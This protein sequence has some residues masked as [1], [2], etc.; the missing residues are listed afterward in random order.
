M[1]SILIYKYKNRNATLYRC[2]TL[3][4]DNLKELIQFIL[5][6]PWKPSELQRLLFQHNHRENSMASQKCQKYSEMYVLCV[7]IPPNLDNWAR[8]PIS[9]SADCSQRRKKTTAT[10]HFGTLYN[11]LQCFTQRKIRNKPS[12]NPFKLQAPSDPE[13]F[14]RSLAA[15]AAEALTMGRFGFLMPSST[16]LSRQ[17]WAYSRRSSSASA[18]KFP[19][20]DSNSDGE[21]SLHY[22]L[23]VQ[24]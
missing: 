1:D 4:F 9:S 11:A 8:W 7:R 21:T 3:N 6:T 2:T 22:R 18:R 12:S 16:S 17:L 19:K 13:V 5:L 23:S 24:K 10:R 20:P 15:A 14:S